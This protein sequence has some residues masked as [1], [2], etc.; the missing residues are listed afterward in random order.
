MTIYLSLLNYIAGGPASVFDRLTTL[1]RQSRRN[2]VASL[3]HSSNQAPPRSRS[4]YL[5]S[6]WERR[7]RIQ[8][9]RTRDLSP[10]LRRDIGLDI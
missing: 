5:T 9:I 2:A 3:R 8:S 4:T 1:G 6:L 10:H 7:V